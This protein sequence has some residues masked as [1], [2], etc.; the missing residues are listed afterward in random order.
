VEF[1]WLVILL[2]RCGGERKLFRI[3]RYP[4]PPRSSGIIPL[5]RKS[6]QNPERKGVRGQNLE[7]ERLT[8]RSFPAAFTPCALPF[9]ASSE[10]GARLGVTRGLW[11]IA[12]H[13]VPKNEIK[14]K[15]ST[16]GVTGVHRGIRY[17]SCPLSRS[18][19]IDPPS[20]EFRSV[21]AVA[22][23]WASASPLLAK[24]GEKWGHPLYFLWYASLETLR[25]MF[26]RE[27]APEDRPPILP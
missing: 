20:R 18:A 8:P 26:S 10:S 24:D 17:L 3:Y 23:Q 6:P 19:R 2:R 4:L 9:W 1:Y 13:P 14:V 25:Q 5:A 15:V 22:W 12:A 27:N 21:R 7:N 16:T 11:I